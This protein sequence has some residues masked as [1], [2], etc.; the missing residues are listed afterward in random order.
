M[1]MVGKGR[2]KIKV[3]QCRKDTPESIVNLIRQCTEF[4]RDL[5]PD[6]A[7]DVRISCFCISNF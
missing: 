3:E 6:F 5:R 7:R 4:D 2:L 1:W